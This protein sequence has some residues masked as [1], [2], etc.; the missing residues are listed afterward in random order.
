M[1]K[2]STEKHEAPLKALKL[3]WL[4]KSNISLEY[5]TELHGVEVASCIHRI[6][7]EKVLKLPSLHLTPS[8]YKKANQAS[9]CTLALSSP[10]IISF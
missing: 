10:L 2:K 5:G 3:M 1:S 9:G 8:G 6:E 4:L 7:M